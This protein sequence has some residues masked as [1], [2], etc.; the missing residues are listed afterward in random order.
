MPQNGAL[1]HSGMRNKCS[2]SQLPKFN[3]AVSK[4]YKLKSQPLHTVVTVEQLAQ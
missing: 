3:T 2:H 1:R 4:S